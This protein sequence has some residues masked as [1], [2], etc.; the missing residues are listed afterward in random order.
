MGT[1]ARADR[2]TYLPMIGVYLM[3]AWLLKEVAE[4]WPKTRTALAASAVVALLALSAVTF[5]QVGYWADSY[6]IFK[7][8]VQV[9]ERNYFAYNHIGIA[10]DSDGKK[11][12]GGDPQA[13]K[14]LFDRLAENFQGPPE[15]TERLATPVVLGLLGREF[16]GGRQES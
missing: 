13:A 2:Y 14:Q 8:A 9:T 1:Q 16:P 7:H 15:E 5:R 6:T 10:F 11:M 12:T 4:R 3:A